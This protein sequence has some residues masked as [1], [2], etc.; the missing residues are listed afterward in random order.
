MARRPTPKYKIRNGMTTE[1]L[2]NTEHRRDKSGRRTG[3]PAPTAAEAM[4][5]RTVKRIFKGRRMDEQ[6][7]GGRMPNAGRDEGANTGCDVYQ[8]TERDEGA[9]PGC[10]LCVNTG[11]ATKR[12]A[13]NGSLY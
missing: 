4:A 8:S 7:Q 6:T 13:T 9:N 1:V 11:T 3:A 10:N 2:V 5:A 12:T